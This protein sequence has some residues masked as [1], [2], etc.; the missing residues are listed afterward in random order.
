MAPHSAV[1]AIDH[2][3]IVVTR[4][5]RDFAA[6]GVRTLDPFAVPP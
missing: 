1:T 2:D 4:N 3:L 6:A 5:T